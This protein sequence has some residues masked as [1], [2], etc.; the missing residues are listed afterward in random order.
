MLTEK[1]TVAQ[2]VKNSLPFN[3]HELV[4]LL[5]RVMGGGRT[6]CVTS[7]S[8]IIYTNLKQRKRK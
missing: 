2:V 5:Q 4:G 6:I 8:V 1:L 3:K 7:P